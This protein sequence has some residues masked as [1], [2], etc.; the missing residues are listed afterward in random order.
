M[1][2]GCSLLVWLLASAA[3]AQPARE[4]LSFDEVVKRAL[5]HN[6]DVQV[7]QQEILRAQ[8]LLE[9]VRSASLPTLTANGSYTRLDGDRVLN[10]NVIA[11]ANQLAGNL[12]VSVPLV[13]PKSWAQWA[14]AKENVDV[15]RLSTDDV[16]RRLAI[17]VARTYLGVIAQ[18]RVLEVAERA[19]AT[20]EAHYDFAHQRYSSGYGTRVDE[21]RAA[22]EVA[23]DLSQV[24]RTE[25]Q[26]ARLREA[27]GVLV[28]VDWAVDAADDAPLL[29]EQPPPENQALRDAAILRS[30]VR[31]QRGRLTLAKHVRRDSFTDYLPSLSGSFMP[32]YQNPP[33]LTVPE[34][35][36]QAQI[37]LTLPLYDGGLRYGQIKERRTLAREAELQLEGLLRQASSDVRAAE[38]DVRRS[39]AALAFAVD[40]ATQATAALELTTLGYRAGASTNIEVID[41]ERQARDAATAVAAA[42]DARRQ[43]VLDLLVAGGRFPR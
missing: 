30:D 13:Q 10:G 32:F 16:K 35:G 18:R 23:S 19:L 5:E 26:L 12:L 4:R 22:Q 29:A 14:H 11:G 17:V 27:L 15:T 24:Q 40:A 41:A 42:E 3:G 21:V 43:A 31:L 9:Q 25:A 33:T 7:A 39:I 36:W 34:S 8:A 2:L 20:A 6:P 38:Q 37:T 28:G 1:R